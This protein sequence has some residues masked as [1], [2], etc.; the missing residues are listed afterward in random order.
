M[1]VRHRL[2][3]YEGAGLVDEEVARVLAATGASVTE[4]IAGRFYDVRADG[5]LLVREPTDDGV[6]DL[7]ARLFD[8]PPGTAE[9]DEV[10]RAELCVLVPGSR[11]PRFAHATAV[12]GVPG[13]RFR[14]LDAAHAA[15]KG[16]REAL[17][18]EAE[19][20]TLSHLRRAAALSVVVVFGERAR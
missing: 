17:G 4:R 15:L 8:E 2:G 7:L 16:E 9:P 3:L 13:W 6:V 1:T 18:H 12:D 11:D 20:H 14:S 5:N 10:A 19:P